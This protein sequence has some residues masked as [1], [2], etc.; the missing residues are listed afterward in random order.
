MVILYLL[1][2]TA[3]ESAKRDEAR[4]RRSRIQDHIFGIFTADLQPLASLPNVILLSR[5]QIGRIN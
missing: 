5:G 3:I 4:E 1:N 2:T